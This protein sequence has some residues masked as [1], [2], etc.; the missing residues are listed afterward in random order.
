MP[1]RKRGDTWHIRFQIGGNRIE[2]SLG[3]AATKADALDYEAKLRREIVSGKLGHAP[4]RSLTDALARWL[5]G[6]AATLKSYDNLLSKVRAIR[7]ECEGKPLEQIVQVAEEIKRKGIAAKLKPATINRR[8]AI[9]RRVANLAHEQWDWLDQP[10]GAKIKLLRGEKS[11]H[12]YLTPEQ[13]DTLADHCKDE[14]VRI[15]IRL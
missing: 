14:T 5:K 4:K 6:E 8:L 3:P 9:L 7:T 12:I 10:L 2:R 1:V 15:A 13:V 11:R